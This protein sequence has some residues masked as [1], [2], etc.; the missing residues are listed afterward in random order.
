MAIAS[1]PY[2]SRISVRRRAVRS[3]ACSYEIGENPVSVRTMFRSSRSGCSPWRYRFTPLGHSIP[4]LNGNSSHGS[5]PTTFS[6]RTLSWMPHC[7]PQN[8]QWVFTS[9]SGGRLAASSQPPGGA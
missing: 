5:K 6:S 3:S 8:E 9:R 7:I 2:L 1:G 4:R